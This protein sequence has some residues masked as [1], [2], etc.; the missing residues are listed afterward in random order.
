MGGSWFYPFPKSQFFEIHG[1]KRKPHPFGNLGQ[2]SVLGI[3][4]GVS[5]RPLAYI[6]TLFTPLFAV[7]QNLGYSR[8][9]GQTIMCPQSTAHTYPGSISGTHLMQSALS[10]L[11]ALNTTG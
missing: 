1:S 10:N 2:T 7:T 4:H 9:I 11:D 8:T 3:T 5:T 6:F